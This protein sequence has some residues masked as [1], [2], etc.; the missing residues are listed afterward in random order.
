MM[1]IEAE[2]WRI[3]MSMQNLSKPGTVTHEAAIAMDQANKRGLGLIFGAQKLLLEEMVFAGN[4]LMERAQSE[5][6]LL[7]E[8]AAKMAEA[9]SVRDYR[10][11]YQECS[12]HQIEFVRRDCDRVWSHGEHFL[13]TASNL[14]NS[15]SLN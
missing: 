9:H 8:L 13:E 3:S 10:T 4:E 2:K 6:H 7:S 14:F 15:R 5:M 12:K 11:M 1:S